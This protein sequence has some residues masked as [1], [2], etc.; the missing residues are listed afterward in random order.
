MAKSPDASDR[1]EALLSGAAL[2][3]I[4]AAGKY[5]DAMEFEAFENTPYRY[6]IDYDIGDRVRVQSN[7]GNIPVT[8]ARV[9]EYVRSDD[10]SGFHEYPVLSV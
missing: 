6:G 4:S 10:E 1:W 5:K 8:P 3:A 2:E 7:I 9:I